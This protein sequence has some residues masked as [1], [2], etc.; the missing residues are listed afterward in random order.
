MRA[1]DPHIFTVLGDRTTRH[2]DALRLQDSGDLLVGQR[3]AGVFLFDELFDT[4][5]KDQQRS[6][7]A[8]GALRAFTE[9]K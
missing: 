9:E 7:A 6:A 5:L 1:G 4:A 8:L 2:L 3:T